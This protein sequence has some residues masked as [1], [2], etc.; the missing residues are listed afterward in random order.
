MTTDASASISLVV[1]WHLAVHWVLYLLAC[2]GVS[3]VVMFVS[4]L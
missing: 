2:L 1:G 3:V 4:L